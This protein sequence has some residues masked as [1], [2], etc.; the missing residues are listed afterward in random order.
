MGSA[1]MA[2][3]VNHRDKLRGFPDR[4]WC[5][6]LKTWLVDF[7]FY[8]TPQTVQVFVQQWCRA[9]AVCSVM[10]FCFSQLNWN[11]PHPLIV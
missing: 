5:L 11:N 2:I 9:A 4:A 10:E 6:C 8:E 3:Y 1:K 7:K